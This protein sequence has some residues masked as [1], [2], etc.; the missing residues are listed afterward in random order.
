[1]ADKK[2][3][4]MPDNDLQKDL[5]AGNEAVGEYLQKQAIK[6]G[7]YVEGDKASNQNNPENTVDTSHEKIHGINE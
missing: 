4:D 5:V 6:Q 7:A 1:M 3:T 2:K